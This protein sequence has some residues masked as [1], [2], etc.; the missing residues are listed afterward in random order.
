MLINLPSFYC[1]PPSNFHQRA[2]KIVLATVQPGCSSGRKVNNVFVHG[3]STKLAFRLFDVLFA[4]EFKKI[5]T[6][7][8]DR[9]NYPALRV[10]KPWRWRKFLLPFW[11]G[12]DDDG[13]TMIT[14]SIVVVVVIVTRGGLAAAKGRRKTVKKD[15]FCHA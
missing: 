1:P 14:S 4:L 7:L 6:P 9:Q 15:H 2:P 8:H 11:D 12:W 3:E 10:R 5:S 13:R